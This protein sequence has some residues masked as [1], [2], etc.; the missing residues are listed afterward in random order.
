MVVERKPHPPIRKRRP[1][2]VCLELGGRMVQ[3][4]EIEDTTQTMCVSSD[5]FE[6]ILQETGHYGEAKEAR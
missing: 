4:Y 2:C 1:K 3:V 6:A 5:L